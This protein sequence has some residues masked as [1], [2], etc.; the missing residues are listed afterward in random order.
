MAFNSIGGTAVLVLWA[1]LAGT[2]ASIVSE[3]STIAVGATAPMFVATRSLVIVARAASGH[4]VVVNFNLPVISL[5]MILCVAPLH[6][7][8]SCWH[9]FFCLLVSLS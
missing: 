3:R 1:N 4:V 7:L 6:H 2:A 5:K 9:N 8:Q